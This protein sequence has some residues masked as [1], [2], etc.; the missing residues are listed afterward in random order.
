MNAAARFTFQAEVHSELVQT[1]PNLV[2]PQNNA[3]RRFGTVEVFH[4]PPAVRIEARNF[5]LR[6]DDPEGRA[7]FVGPLV[8]GQFATGNGTV[9]PSSFSIVLRTRSQADRDRDA[10]RPVTIFGDAFLRT[11]FIQNIQALG[12]V[13]KTYEAMEVVDVGIRNPRT[14]YVFSTMRLYVNEDGISIMHVETP[15][16]ATIFR[17]EVRNLTL[18]DVAGEHRDQRHDGSFFFY[19]LRLARRDINVPVDANAGV[20]LEILL[21]FIGDETKH[22]FISNELARRGVTVQPWRRGA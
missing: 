21:S 17:Q 15:Q 20:E 2:A 12:G 14:N 6:I 8:Q 4:A 10:L 11:S 13:V 19:N 1:E 18:M 5:R 16:G 3:R 7:F 9:V 22:A